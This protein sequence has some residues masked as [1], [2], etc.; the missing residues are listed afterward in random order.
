MSEINAE[1]SRSLTYTLCVLSSDPVKGLVNTTT[2][3]PRGVVE[4]IGAIHSGVHQAPQIMGSKVRTTGKVTGFM[5]GLKEGGKVRLGLFP[6][7]TKRL[8]TRS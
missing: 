1:I 4:I 3:I 8:T 6:D 7:I 5:S 2:A